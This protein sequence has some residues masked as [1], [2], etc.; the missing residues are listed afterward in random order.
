MQIHQSEEATFRS[1][2]PEDIDLEPFLGCRRR[3]DRH[4]SSASAWEL[5]RLHHRGQGV[6]GRNADAQI[7]T[8]SGGRKRPRRHPQLDDRGE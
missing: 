7:S 8:R 2:L 6:S 3:R 1:M 4:S 5:V